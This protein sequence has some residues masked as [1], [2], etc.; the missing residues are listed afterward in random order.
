[1]RKYKLSISWLDDSGIIRTYEEITKLTTENNAYD[2]FVELLDKYHPG[3]YFY[4]CE[5][6]EM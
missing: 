4:L 5:M 2:R 1:M 3:R 6:K